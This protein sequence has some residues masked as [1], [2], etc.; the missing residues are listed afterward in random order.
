MSERAGEKQM[1]REEIKKIL[2]HREPMLLVD[3][4]ELVDGKS[5]GKCYIRGEDRK[6][7]V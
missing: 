1:N 5:L 2:P 7:V 4:V 3:E 6:S